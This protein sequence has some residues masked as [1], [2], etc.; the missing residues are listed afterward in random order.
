MLHFIPALA[1]AS[2]PH[3]ATSASTAKPNQTSQPKPYQ[4]AQTKPPNKSPR[5]VS[6]P[7]WQQA[8]RQIRDELRALVLEEPHT[9]GA[10]CVVAP[11]CFRLLLI[12]LDDSWWPPR[13]RGAAQRGRDVRAVE[14]LGHSST[15]L[16]MTRLTGLESHHRRSRQQPTSASSGSAVAGGAVAAAVAAS[17]GMHPLS[18]RG[19]GTIDEVAEAASDCSQEVSAAST[20]ARRR[21][22]LMRR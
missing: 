6:R 15:D 22:A 21:E 19:V 13:A 9:A 5:L 18:C 16:W 20:V 17:G 4:R 10:T 14:P 7:G 2:I 8:E 12:A 1:T 3:A 11:D